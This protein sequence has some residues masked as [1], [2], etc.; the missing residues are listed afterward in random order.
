MLAV[1]DARVKEAAPFENI[2]TVGMR[3][4]DDTGMKEVPD[5]YTKAGVLEQVIREERNILQ[6]HIKKEPEAIPQIFVP[7]K[8]PEFI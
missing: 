2:Y 7:Y 8:R 5:G 4:I 3:G 6:K 1:M